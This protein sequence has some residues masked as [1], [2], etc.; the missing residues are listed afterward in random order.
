MKLGTFQFG[1]ASFLL[2]VGLSGCKI[3]QGENATPIPSTLSFPLQS[4][5]KALV[6]NGVTKSFTVSGSC[7][8]AGVLVTTPASTAATFE[9]VAALSAAATITASLTDCTPA[10]TA[11]TITDYYDSN[12]TLLGFFSVGGNYG[13]YLTPPAMPASV[14][15]GG[16][17]VVGTATLYADST[18]A[19]G[20]GTQ[21]MSY[22]VEAD[23]PTTAIVNLVSNTYNASG[24]LTVTE[25]DR[26][27]IAATGAL[28]PVSS[29][30]QY[31]NGSTT[32]TIY[33]F[34]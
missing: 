20:H 33:T 34:I 7:S 26:Y 17:G 25:Q 5:Y 9:G 8:G 13:V 22:V 21:V 1:V 24:T 29:D 6:A 11:T 4:A 16:T 30:I 31:A 14:T 12:Y 10:S 27:R 19:V 15:V 32:H 28:V 23:T 18:K 3:G 2:L